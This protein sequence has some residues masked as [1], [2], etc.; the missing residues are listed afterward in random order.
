[1]RPLVSRKIALIF[2]L[3][4]ATI[5]LFDYHGFNAYVDLPLTFYFTAAAIFLFYYFQKKHLFWLI[6]SGLFSGLAAWTKNEG[7]MLAALLFIVLLYFLLKEK[8]SKKDVFFYFLSF[9]FFVLPWFIFK[10]VHHLG[11][12]NVDY[13]TLPFNQFHPEIFL[14]VLKQVFLF[15]SFHLWPGI[16]VLIL[17][18]NL[19]KFKTNSFLCLF[20]VVFGG[21]IAFFILYLFTANA[22]HVLDGHIVSRNLMTII[23]L[24]IFLSALL[25]DD[26]GIV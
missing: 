7:L 13:Q 19:S 17:L 4:L 25:S 10:G 14:S 6:L 11:F 1:L 24:S 3:F 16:F 22:Q 26:K 20:L 8:G 18:I 15:H 21:L 23:P 9:I 2:T 5:P 12:S